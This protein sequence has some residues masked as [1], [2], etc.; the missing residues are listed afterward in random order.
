MDIFTGEK[1][2]QTRL[3][4]DKRYRSS[5]SVTVKIILLLVPFLFISAILFPQSTGKSGW[6]YILMKDSSELSIIDIE[7]GK[8]VKIIS[9]DGGKPDAIFPT[10]GGKFVFVTYVDSPFVSAVDAEDQEVYRNFRLDYQGPPAFT[11]SPMGETVYA[12]EPGTNRITVFGHSRS[13]LDEKLK[14]S[15]G[16]PDTTGIFNRRGTR[17]FRSNTKGL[18][19]IYAKTQE[20]IEEIG[21][22]GGPMVW[23][24]SPDYRYLWGAGISG[25]KVVVIDESRSKVQKELDI[26]IFP[27]QPTFSADG[28]R[29][30]FISSSGDRILVINGRRHELEKEIEFSSPID[31]ITIDGDDN[32]WVMSSASGSIIK[33]DGR[34][35]DVSDRI[36]LNAPAKQIK[37]VTLKKGEGFACF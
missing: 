28:N 8:V 29:V 37:Y 24:F 21:F 12:T 2:R 17:Y 16:E 32:L 27:T 35:L 9:L 4:T 18:A 7:D 13:H 36:E 11:F 33:V 10:P 30:Y 6:I 3:Y 14:F 5:R 15:V 22:Q 1:L 23:N 25:N 31:G 20:V 19:V 26:E 34:S